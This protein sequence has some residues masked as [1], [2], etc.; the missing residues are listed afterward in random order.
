MGMSTM[1]SDDFSRVPRSQVRMLLRGLSAT[2][3][4]P[5]QRSGYGT[6]AKLQT[7]KGVGVLNPD[8][9]GYHRIDVIDPDGTSLVSQH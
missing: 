6:S 5:L 7:L 2:R 8:I 1:S 4:H 9:T 3:R